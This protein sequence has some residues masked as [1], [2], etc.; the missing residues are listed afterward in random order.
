MTPIGKGPEVE[1]SRTP[2]SAL[3][4]TGASW[5]RLEANSEQRQPLP[6]GA[7]PREQVLKSRALLLPRVPQSMQVLA[8]S[9]LRQLQQR[10]H[11]TR[12]Q[13]EM[14]PTQNDVGRLTWV[15]SRF[16]TDSSAPW[17]WLSDVLQRF[18]KGDANLVKEPAPVLP[19]HLSLTNPLER[20]VL[21][22]HFS[23]C[24]RC[25]KSRAS[26]SVSRSA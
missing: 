21:L 25:I 13:F 1:L 6:V 16:R 8:E 9:Q 5:L 14:W 22:N 4:P 7:S 15:V 11:L 23:K 3:V 24:G 12:A 20:S 17:Q 18:D 19:T 10:L 2:L 26:P